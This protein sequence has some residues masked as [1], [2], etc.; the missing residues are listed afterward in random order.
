MTDSAVPGE[1]KPSTLPVILRELAWTIHKRAPERAQVGP[2]PT[3]EIALLKQVVDDPG[4]TVGE[5]AM[6]LGL[7]QPNASAAVRVLMGRGMV[8]RMVDEADHR[9]ARI[10]PT[11]LGRR[12]HEAIAAEWARFVERALERV[13]D[14]DRRAL[15]N[16]AEALQT[17]T[18]RVR[19]PE[20]D[21]STE[22]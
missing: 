15:E 5:L 21:A 20:A 14:S 1:G 7:H 8:E 18:R 19:E 12:E 11:V 10:H 3:T 17:L 22:H 2:L 4:A 9:S 13:G 16:A 6:A